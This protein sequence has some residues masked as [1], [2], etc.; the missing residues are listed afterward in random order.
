[1]KG[2][3]VFLLFFLTWNIA[4]YCGQADG[5]EQADI[6]PVRGSSVQSGNLTPSQVDAYGQKIMSNPDN[7]AIIENLAKNPRIQALAQDPEI[8][9]AIKSGNIQALQENKKF[10]DVVNSPETQEAMKDIKQ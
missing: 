5:V 1:L 10:S 9:Q 3:I 8:I 4:G 2:K 7:A 6:N